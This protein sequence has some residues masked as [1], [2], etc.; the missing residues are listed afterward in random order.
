[1]DQEKVARP[2]SELRRE[3][4]ATGSY[5]SLSGTVIERYIEREVR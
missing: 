3:S 5:L 1:M 4:M 2:Y